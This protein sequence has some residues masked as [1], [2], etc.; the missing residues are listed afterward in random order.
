MQCGHPAAFAGGDFQVQMRHAVAQQVGDGL[1][2]GA[3]AVARGGGYG[4]GIP[5]AVGQADR[6]VAAFFQIR[7]VED[8]QHRLGFGPQFA[9]DGFHGGDLF[10]H[11]R[12]GGVNHM[13]QQVGFVHL[14]ERGL[15][16]FDEVVGQLAD[17]PDGIG[18]QAGLVVGQPELAGGRVERGEQ[19]VVG[20]DAGLG[21][22]VE[23]GGLA[24]IGV[25]D[26]GQQGPAVTAAAAAQFGAPLPDDLELGLDA[27]D[28]LFDAPAVEFELFFA[29]TFQADAALLAFQVRP[30]AAQAGN[31]I[32]EL[33]QF[34]LQPAF[35]TQ[36]ALGED[37]ENQLGAVHDADPEQVFQGAALGGGQVVVENH[38]RGA[39]GGGFFGNLGGLAPADIGGGMDVAQPAD[40]LADN[41]GP[42]GVGQRAQLP[43][44]VFDFGAGR[45]AEVGGDQPCVV[46][47]IGSGGMHQGHGAWAM[48]SASQR[49]SASLKYQ[50]SRRGASHPGGSGTAIR[51]RYSRKASRPS[52]SRRA[53]TSVSACQ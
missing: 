22:G 51:L 38:Q 53:V 17:E 21:E 10:V 20:M 28:A 5:E 31:Q 19:L 18:Q 2:Q 52:L 15:E 25:A 47:G 44:G 1:A 13:Q 27:G 30:Q 42:G 26:Q 46:R 48:R 24:G 41:A 33:R 40:G 49:K 11:P 39:G 23:Q 12:L 36:G 32:A 34:D 9:Q 6:L 14:F 45:V 7:L 16:G 43:Q 4:H 50:R 3:G 8:R 29:G 35:Q 37:V